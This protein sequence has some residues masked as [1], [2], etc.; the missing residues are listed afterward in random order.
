M[1]ASPVV[2]AGVSPSLATTSL[3]DRFVLLSWLQD[4]QRML[5]SHGNHLASLLAYVRSRSAEVFVRIDALQRFSSSDT[6]APW[7]SIIPAPA[8][9]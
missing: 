8:C 7:P 3:V 9:S 2:Y 6:S 4:E 5:A 1:F